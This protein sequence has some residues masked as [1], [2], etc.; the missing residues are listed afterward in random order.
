MTSAHSAALDELRGVRDMR[1]LLSTALG[2]AVRHCEADG[3]VL[4]NIVDGGLVLEAVHQAS[5]DG[6]DPALR[7]AVAA[8]PPQ[9]DR[10]QPRLVAGA[11]GLP[12]ALARALSV[13]SYVSAPVRA[14]DTVFA[15]VLAFRR[16]EPLTDDATTALTFVAGAAGVCAERLLL[17]RQLEIARRGLHELTGSVANTSR[18]GPAPSPVFEGDAPADDQS[19]SFQGDARMLELLTPREGEVLQLLTGGLTNAE[20]AERIGV[21]PGTVKT[22]VREILRKTG[23]SNR[24]ELTYRYLR[25]LGPASAA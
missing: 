2:L 24:A 13:D 9:I 7:D 16:G 10:E 6:V 20:I 17:E 12:A 5:G 21:T 1:A 23:T 25:R 11:E 15:L 3:A 4:L 22:Y 18:Q 8:E 19:S 14:D